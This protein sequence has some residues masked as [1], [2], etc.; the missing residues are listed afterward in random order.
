MRKLFSITGALDHGLGKFLEN[1]PVLLG[2]TLLC[3][4]LSYSLKIVDLMLGDVPVLWGVVRV[5]MSI[6]CISAMVSL[7]QVS[8][9]LQFKRK[10]FS[11]LLVRPMKYIYLIVEHLLFTMMVMM[12]LLLFVIPGI[13]LGVRHCFYAHII[14]DRRVGPFRAFGISS[15]MTN[16][17][18]FDLFCFLVVVGLLNA[19]GSAMLG[20]GLLFTIPL[21]IM[22]FAYIYEKL[23]KNRGVATSLPT[24]VPSMA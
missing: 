8:I 10:P 24:A 11:T 19:I 22:A 1:L 2:L 15:E 17:Y 9:D 18:K 20:V 5:L 21:T 23:L 13:Y 7:V 14:L 16:G 3:V 4:V 12:G 6:L